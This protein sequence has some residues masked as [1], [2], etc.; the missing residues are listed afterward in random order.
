MYLLFYLLE[1]ANPPNSQ[2]PETKTQATMAKSVNVAPSFSKHARRFPK[3]ALSQDDRERQVYRFQHKSM[4]LSIPL[5]Y[6][7]VWKCLQSSYS[8]LQGQV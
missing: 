6:L 5:K 8:G 4:Q 3:P 7:P 2:G 1:K